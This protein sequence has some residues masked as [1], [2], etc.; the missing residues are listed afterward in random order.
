MRSAGGKRRKLLGHA[1]TVLRIFKNARRAPVELF[2][3]LRII[4]SEPLMA[5]QGLISLSPVLALHH[6]ATCLRQFMRN[7]S[8]KLKPRRLGISFQKAISVIHMA[9]ISTR[10]KKT[11]SRIS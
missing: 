8:R 4:L 3:Q 5:G 9:S 6:H 7:R 2:V 1:K 10:N 11:R